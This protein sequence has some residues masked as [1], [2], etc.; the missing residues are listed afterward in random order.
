M[1]LLFSDIITLS[2]FVSCCSIKSPKC[3][4]DNFT[5]TLPMLKIPKKA[6]DTFKFVLLRANPLMFK[7]V[8]LMS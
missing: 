6:T 5:I 3:D 7:V 8:W 1:V 4:I 2:K